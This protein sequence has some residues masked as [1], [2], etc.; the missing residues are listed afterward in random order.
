MKKNRIINFLALAV[1]VVGCQ[2]AI[3]IR[4]PGILDASA[5]FQSVDDLNDGLQ[6]AYDLMDVTAEIHHASVFTDEIRIGYDNGGQGIQLY[7]FNLTPANAGPVTVWARGYQTLGRINRILEAAP[8]IDATGREVERDNILGQCYAI[9]AWANHQML[10]YFTTDYRD[11]NALGI[12][13]ID[14]VAP[15]DIAPLRNTNGEIY[16]AIEDDL[17]QAA[18]LIQDQNSDIFFSRDAV[19]ALRARVAAYRGQYN[20]AAPLAQQLLTAYPLA[21]PTDYNNMFNDTGIG[22]VIFKL[23]RTLND[24]WD[25]QGNTGSN[26]AGGWAGASYAFTGPGLT[27]APYYEMATGLWQSYDPSDQRRDENALEFIN[28]PL[29]GGRD[30]YVVN[31]YRGQERPLMNDLKLFRSSEMLMILAEAAADAGNLN[32]TPNSVAGLLQ[33]IRTARF[34]SAQPFPNFANATAAWGAIVDER[35]IEFAFEGHRYKDLKR[36]GVLANR[37]VSRTQNDCA[38]SG[39]CTLPTTDFRFTW[40]IPQAEFNGNPGLRAQQNPG[41]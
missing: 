4:Q 6:G 28:V 21:E 24:S 36:L 3:D 18:A 7:A 11:D 39:A 20:V 12:P 38:A 1:L 34:G 27:G 10:S 26:A 8:N 2:D 32:N 19:N 25:G 15:T 31:K 33:Q 22:E 37:Q 30:V 41:Y 17:T 16:A 23:E 5:A 14:F 35:R 9:R 29:A 40:P 13:L